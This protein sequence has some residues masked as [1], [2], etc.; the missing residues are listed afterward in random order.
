VLRRCKS[1][2]VRLASDGWVRA[3]A[4]T[5]YYLAILVGVVLMYGLR[6]FTNPPFVYQGF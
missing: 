3:A 5:V 4:L 2:A 6:N 1:I